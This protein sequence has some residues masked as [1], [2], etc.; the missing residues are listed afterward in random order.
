[1]RKSASLFLLALLVLG[2]TL[3]G[4]GASGADGLPPTDSGA[5]SAIMIFPVG[6]KPNPDGAAMNPVAFNHVNH[7]KWMARAKKDC[8]VCHHTGDPAA[9]T[10]CHTVEGSPEGG[11]V[12]LEKAMHTPYITKTGENPP[13]SCVSC[14]MAEQKPRECAGCHARLVLNKRTPPNWCNV[15][16]NQTP[17]MTAT[18]LQEGIKATLPEVQNEK[19]G[20]ASALA[21]P[22]VKY[23]SVMDGPYK[24]TINNFNG[25]YEPAI[26]N[27]RHHVQV[28]LDRIKNSKLADAFHTQDATICMTCHHNSPPSKTPPK[29]ASCHTASIDLEQLARPKLMAAYHLQ[30]M[31][32]HQ[33][34]KVARP[35]STDC[36]TCHKPRPGVKGGLL[37]E[38]L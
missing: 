22:T 13:S 26:F 14:H 15:C 38:G 17:G 16:H 31:N 33:D 12:N 9:C 23:W 37:G 28:L 20:E 24:V 35:R 18:L 10:T 5:P 6:E 4:S 8:I 21:R 1:M 19:L 30:C 25:P 29:C 3:L 11:N 2:W 34:M 36:A 27:H 7:E 32:C